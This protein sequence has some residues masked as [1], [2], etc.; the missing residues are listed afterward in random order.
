M[1][2]DDHIPKFHHWLFSFLCKEELYDELA[3]DLE[4]TFAENYQFLGPDQARSIYKKEVLKMLRPSV[5]R[6]FKILPK[7]THMDMFKNYFKISLRNI[8]RDKEHSLISIFGL[9]S[10]ILASVL[11]FQYTNFETSYDQFHDQ[12]D[13]TIYRI[14]RMVLDDESQELRNQNATTFHGFHPTVALEVPEV[15]HS[16]H[17]S[18]ADGAFTYDDKGHNTDNVFFTYG[19]FFDVFSFELISGDKKDLDQPGTVF[20]SESLANRIYGGQDPMGKL[21]TY[22]DNNSNVVVQGQVK[23]IF[24]DFPSNSHLKSEAMLSMTDF[25]AF[26]DNGW[27]GNRR[28][29]QLTWRWLGF[30]TYVKARKDASPELLEKK[31]GDF[32][33]KYRSAFDKANGRTQ[34]VKP[35]ALSDIHFIKDFIQQLEPAGDRN[36]V[37]LFKLIGILIL[38][39]GWVNYINLAS[40]KSVR[41][42]KEVGVRKTMGALKGQLIK[43]FLLESIFINLIALIIAAGLTI[44]V[45]PNF[46]NL[47][48][49]PV[50][51]N[52]EQYIPFWSIYLLLFVAGAILS[53]LYPA[54]VLTKFNPILVLRGSFKSS[55]HGTRL[56]KALMF[57]QFATVLIMLSG[58]LVIRSQ[59][60]YLVNYDIGMSIDQTLVID[61]PPPFLRDST[62]TEKIKAFQGDI[63]GIATI[64][65]ST[66][67]SMVPGL[68]NTWGLT[69]SRTDRPANESIH[70][71]NASIDPD[72]VSFYNMEIIAGRDFENELV[73]DQN[74]II[75]NQTALRDLEF[76][77]PE[78]AIGA[79]LRFPNSDPLQIVGIAKDFNYAGMKFAIEPMAMHLNT[80]GTSPFISLRL[81]TKDLKNTLNQVEETYLSFFPGAAFESTFLDETFNNIYEADQKFQAVIKFFTI[82]AILISCLGIFGLSSFL[83]N[84]KLKEV[85][86]RKV[87]G[88]SVMEILRVLT[89]EYIWLITLSTII[90]TPI[91]YFL[92]DGWLN[93]FLVRVG[94]SPIS[95]VL[96]VIGLMVILCL[97]IGSKTWKAVRVNPSKTLKAE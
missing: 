53:G 95:F 40:A 51:D 74:V 60:Q 5:I 66:N 39:I 38:L 61:A 48:G 12:S 63:E 75:I 14:P 46:H 44:L 58:V 56:R 79:R 34:V 78:S 9:A 22:N 10:A 15:L 87:L 57:F 18:S 52:I 1:N 83:I 45:I 26:A 31:L 89:T 82:V 35:Q 64:S 3:G 8:W 7:F 90:A 68:P 72:F 37:S 21:L 42:A 67:S 49:A 50:F 69:V 70:V 92:I 71:R 16:T 6:K 36:M 17:F 47:V 88:A 76:D 2:H 28:L 91:A 86:I 80:Q 25:N 94:I 84:Q 55:T 13:G 32:V 65:G 29:S 33:V 54:L 73:G 20:L 30:H 27:F 59:I 19:S 81:A 11:I 43:L 97:T 24:R 4:E 62:F 96:P 41:R 93:N 85:S 77:S 23:G